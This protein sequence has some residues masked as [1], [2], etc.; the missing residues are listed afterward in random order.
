MSLFL[1]PTQD[2]IQTALVNFL[3][4]VL[5]GI[6]VVEG[7]DNRV[8]EPKSDDF[9]VMTCIQSPRLGTNVEEFIDVQFTASISG[10]TMT[11]TAVEFGTI[12]EGATLFGQG[13]ADNTTIVSGPGGVGTYVITPS[14]TVSSETM[15]AGAS[16]KMQPTQVVFQI[17][18]H[19]EQGFNNTQILTTVFRSQVAVDSLGADFDI[20][21][22][23][24]S[25]PR[26]APFTNENDQVENRWML[27]L[28]LQ[29]NQ[30][31]S[32]FP[33]EFASTAGVTVINVEAT[34]PS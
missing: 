20:S 6:E 30:V 32:G 24:A 25:D 5:P 12:L 33:Q 18:V 34:Y 16:T 1:T 17:D 23:Y 10:T 13:V 2:Q 27:E 15:A 29:V 14:Q 4:L 9:I 19:G 22:L 7:Q 31:V 21:P 26:Q 3:G 11:V 8:P 28:N